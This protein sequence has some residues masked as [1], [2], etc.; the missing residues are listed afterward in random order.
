MQPFPSAQAPPPWV[1][2]LPPFSFA[3]VLITAN[4]SPRPNY[5]LTTLDNLLT[6]GGLRAAPPELH[7]FTII[8]GTADDLYWALDTLDPLAGRE[9]GCV[10]GALPANRNVAYAL[11]FAASVGAPW[12][13]FLEDDIDV[14]ADFFASTAAWLADFADPR[15]PIF[16]LGANYPQVD[17]PTNYGCAW[18]YPIDK[19]YGTQA[20]ALRADTAVS[21]AD[22][23]DT[24]CYSRTH[25]GTAY[26]LLIADWARANGYG[27][28]L[29]PAPSFVQHIGRESVIRPRA[30]THVFPS[31]RGHRWSY[32][33]DAAASAAPGDADSGSDGSSNR[34]TKLFVDGQ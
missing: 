11:R 14:C 6:H 8:D 9:V 4:R 24:H 1:R 3:A 32:V 21:V 34:S 10:S 12:V 31:W 5:L 29:T 18:E 22:Y 28:F 33:R 26:D 16:P 7:T 17:A 13:L 19:F 23:I 2:P 25:D 15:Y 20:L 27:S 30:E